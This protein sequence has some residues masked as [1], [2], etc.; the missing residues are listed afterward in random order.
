MKQWEG[1]QNKMFTCHEWIV[2]I[3]SESTLLSKTALMLS[4]I[5]TLLQKVFKFSVSVNSFMSKRKYTQ[6]HREF[7]QKGKLRAKKN[8]TCFCTIFLFTC[9]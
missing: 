2:Q 1:L 3:T 4:I 6:I 7:L 5:N 8:L 9:S